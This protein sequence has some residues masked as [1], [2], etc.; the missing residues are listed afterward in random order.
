[1]FIRRTRTR[2]IG[3][4]YFTFRLVHSERSGSTV[5]QRTLLN[6]GRHFDVVQS[7]WPVLCRR[8]NE[9]L[10]GQMS[11]ACDCP[12]ALESHAQHIADQLLARQRIGAASA[13]ANPGHDFQPLDVDS[14]ELIRPRSVG[15]EHVGRWAMDQLG[16]RTRLEE[17]GISASLRD[18]AIGS[19]IARMARPSSERATRRWLS[20][21]SALGELLGVDFETMGPMRLYRASDALMAHREAIE[22]HLFDRAMGLFDLQATVTLYVVSVNCFCRRV[23]SSGNVTE[24]FASPSPCREPHRSP[25]RTYPR[26]VPGSASLNLWRS[27]GQGVGKSGS[28]GHRE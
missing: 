13:P 4:H 14:L 8:I 24:D 23:A 6:L 1:M 20:E 21:R 16:L 12:P 18:A 17:L 7:H 26:L 2:S 10:A 11:L 28:R 15:V 9:L 19:I 22:H 25:R 27:G 3:E 5:R